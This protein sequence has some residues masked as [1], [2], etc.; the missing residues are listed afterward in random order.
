VR[1]ISEKVSYLQGLS[2]GLNISDG[3]PQGKII[4]GILGVLDDIAGMLAEMRSDLDTVGEYIENIDD[5]L[6]ELEENFK[7]D[8]DIIE[9]K[10]DNCGEELVFDADLMEDEDVIEIICPRCNEVVFVNDGSFDFEY[11]DYGDEI[12]D[13]R[14]AR[15]TDA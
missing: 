9:V 6:L 2:E 1:D 4:T 15:N 11:D 5:D 12:E 10:C 7:R 13:G 14:T 3:N 8:Q